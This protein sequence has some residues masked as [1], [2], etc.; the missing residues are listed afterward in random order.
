MGAETSPVK[1]PS[2]SQK[3]FWPEMAIFVDL[4]ASTAAEMAVK[5]GAITTSQWLAF[6]TSGAQAEKKARVSASVLNIFQLPAITRRRMRASKRE[7]SDNAETSLG[8]AQG[9]Q[10]AQR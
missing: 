10:G 1:A 7:E 9:K 3:R 4:A 6:A 5:G 8:S 2:F